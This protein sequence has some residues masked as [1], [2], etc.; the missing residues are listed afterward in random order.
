[1]FSDTVYEFSREVV[2]STREDKSASVL[3]IDRF[4][5]WQPS[6][7]SQRVPSTSTVSGEDYTR[8]LFLFSKYKTK[9]R[10][11]PQILKFKRNKERIFS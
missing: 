7:S 5:G 6:K 11:D 2:A 8:G 3:G 10:R 1:M 4:R 9:E